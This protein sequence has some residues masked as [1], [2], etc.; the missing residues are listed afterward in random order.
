MVRRDDGAAATARRERGERLEAVVT[1]PLPPLGELYRSHGPAVLRRARQLLG[2][3]EEA[4]DVLQDVFASLLRDPAQY[5]G[6]SSPMTFL[7]GMT[8]HA[9]LARL[10]QRR[11]QMRLLR[12]QHAGVDEASS[13][14][15]EALVEL[16]AW[17][18]T[19]PDDLAQVAIYYH[20]DDLTQD[21]IA[22]VM[23]C[24]RQWVGKL[25]QR[26]REPARAGSEP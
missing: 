16:R 8:T 13:P 19:L 7:Y 9:A 12:V 10:R 3:D 22:E 23:G 18:A 15:H 4:R 14:G 21:E 26:V 5:Q 24:S 1:V 17:L 2:N 25:L 20:L 6:R 11:N